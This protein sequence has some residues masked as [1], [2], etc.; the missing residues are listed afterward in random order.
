MLYKTIQ[1]TKGSF[2]NVLTQT[3]RYNILNLFFTK[4]LPDWIST[5]NKSLHLGQPYHLLIHRC[6]YFSYSRHRLCKS[7]YSSPWYV[8][9]P[10]DVLLLLHLFWTQISIPP[11][12]VCGALIGGWG[13]MLMSVGVESSHWHIAKRLRSW[14]SSEADCECPLYLLTQNLR[15]SFFS[16]WAWNYQYIFH[17]FVSLCLKISHF[18]YDIFCL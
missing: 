1:I 12:Q 15:I 4:M 9:F 7:L 17:C 5:V 11:L 6:R 16:W 10:P 8:R 18:I 3:S 13:G 2:N 14:A